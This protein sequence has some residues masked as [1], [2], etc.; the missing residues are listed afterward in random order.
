M[1][2]NAFGIGWRLQEWL[3]ALLWNTQVDRCT[4]PH[5]TPWRRM[6]ENYIIY[7]QNNT[8]YN[9]KGQSDLKIL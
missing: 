2:K 6:M 4:G 9:T 1:I 8:K 3:V 7:P 5:S